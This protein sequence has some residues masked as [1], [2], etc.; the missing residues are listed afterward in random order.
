MLVDCYLQWANEWFQRLQGSF[1]ALVIITCK[2]ANSANGA[3]GNG[4][5]IIA[6]VASLVACAKEFGQSEE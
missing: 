5:I 4:I 2:W 1:R 3:L 6:I